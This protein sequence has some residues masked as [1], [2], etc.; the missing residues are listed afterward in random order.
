MGE[1]RGADRTVQDTSKAQ[2]EAGEVYS[3]HGKVFFSNSVEDRSLSKRTPH[4]EVLKGFH[5]VIACT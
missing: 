1:W 3:E 4:G 5:P 2:E